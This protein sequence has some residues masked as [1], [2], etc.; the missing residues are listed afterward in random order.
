MK[1]LATVLGVA[2]LLGGCG[3]EAP[4]PASP[5]IPRVTETFTARISVNESGGTYFYNEPPI[6]RVGARGQVDVAASF[7]SPVACEYYLCVCQGLC[8]I[9]ALPYAAG[10]GPSLSTT[11][12][13]VPGD[14]QVLVGGSP[15]AALK[16]TEVELSYTATVV[17]P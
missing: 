5:T 8:K 9:C 12:T 2:L 1:H 14:Y 4:A 3:G 10:P 15:C 17:H 16:G 7:V 13:L 11:G 6:V